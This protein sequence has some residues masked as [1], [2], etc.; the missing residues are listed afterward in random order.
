MSDLLPHETQ[1]HVFLL[2]H[3]VRSTKSKV[4]F[5]SVPP[6]PSDGDGLDES[7]R[8]GSGPTPPFYGVRNVSDFVAAPMPRWD[9]PE[10]WCTDAGLETIRRTGE[11][12]MHRIFYGGSGGGASS[13]PPSAV[14]LDIL[15]DPVRRDADTASALSEGIANFFAEAPNVAST[16][17]ISDVRYD[18]LLFHPFFEGDG[19]D[20]R[21]EGL[22]PEP[23]SDRLAEDIRRRI[24]AVIPPVP[25]LRSTLEL[26]QDLGGV[27]PAGPL[28]SPDYGGADPNTVAVNAETGKLEG[29]INL[30]KLLA[31]EAFY[32]R[33]GGIVPPFLPDATADEVY[34]LLAWAHYSRSVSSVDNAKFAAR[35][36]V[37][38]NS[39]LEALG[40]EDGNCNEDVGRREGGP[41]AEIKKSAP[42]DV[43]ATTTVT[44]FVGH[45]G[46]LDAVATAFGLR[47]N[48][49]DPF[50]PD[51]TGEYLPTPPGSALHFVRRGKGGSV[52]AQ[53]LYPV[54]VASERPINNETKENLRVNSA[55][56]G[57]RRRGMYEKRDDVS[58]EELKKRLLSTVRKF[59]E[60]RECYE[61]SFG[62]LPFSCA[63]GTNFNSGASL[64]FAK[65]FI[66]MFFSLV[67]ASL[68]IKTNCKKGKEEERNKSRSN[69]EEVNSLLS[70]EKRGEIL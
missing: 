20:G 53:F 10:L 17:D 28:V 57:F 26:L 14:R 3:C 67:C 51:K 65:I 52:G 40:N 69:C 13:P 60:A 34:G 68:F 15:S 50:Y 59:P 39:I 8:P 45:D 63:K 48:L 30:I 56:V 46:D 4:N 33:A 41:D 54:A 18:P 24:G 21:G 58:L 64:D 66:V 32:S 38:G 55:P 49:S 9:G 36:A 31:E 16:V 23:A 35:G 11:I 12:V 25:D 47:W 5:R 22:C 43:A 19:D 37:L 62:R 70:C 27:G 61:R 6:P 7:G 42:E 1:N 29:P 44:I 2:R